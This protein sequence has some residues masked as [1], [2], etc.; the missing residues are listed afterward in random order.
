MSRRLKKQV[1]YE[2]IQIVKSGYITFFGFLY[3]ILLSVIIGKAV[4]KD[5]PAIAVMD[6]KTTM[7]LTMLCII[8]LSSTFMG[9]GAIYSI[10][11]ENGI[12]KRLELFGIS[13]LDVIKSRIIAYFIFNIVSIAIYLTA[14]FL[15]LGYSTPTLSGALMIAFIM[16]ILNVILFV[17]AH[18]I[19]NIFRQFS[20]AYGCIMALFFGMMIL[21]G[22]MGITADM[23]PKPLQYISKYVPFSYFRSSFYKL[24][25]GKPINMAYFWQAV[26]VFG[27]ISVLV[28]IAG[29]RKNR[30]SF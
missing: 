19:V 28:L 1:V 23:L 5:V 4:V 6:A 10:D 16:V 9:Y 14:D 15:L 18:G 25:S 8:P 2:L 11:I 20:K 27:M 3:P 7:M 24:W 17:L 13:Q 29:I 21:S 26:I 22:M 30:K 12:P